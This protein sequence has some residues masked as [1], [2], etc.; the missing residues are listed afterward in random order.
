[1]KKKAVILD[2][3]NTIYPVGAIGEQLF[4][5]VV[6]L[7]RQHKTY[8]GNIEDI[9]SAMMKKAFQV[10]AKEFNFGSELLKEGL[11]L[12]GNLSWE[13]PMLPFND[14][15]TIKQ[16]PCQKFL[17]TTGFTKLQSSKV[18]QLGIAD[19]FDDIYIV[20]PSI[21]TLTKKDIFKKIMDDYGFAKEEMIVIG[22]DLDSE[23]KAG[24]ELGIDV[25]LYD[26]KEQYKGLKHIRSIS[27][28]WE[29]SM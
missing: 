6:A 5:P 3:D 11:E 2:L 7:I 1:M 8:D 14:Y 27:S 22:D 20:D 16:W 18:E 19:D 23:I 28:F 9:K 21:S 24:I 26:Y 13:E 12:L 10:V 4:E 15:K 17:V 25:V 29:L